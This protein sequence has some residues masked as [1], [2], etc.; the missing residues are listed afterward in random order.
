MSEEKRK[1]GYFGTILKTV[2]AVVV[3]GVVVALLSGNEE[4]VESPKLLPVVAPSGGKEE[5]P[6]QEVATA[7][8]T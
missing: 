5:L 3:I 6:T 2:G 7:H 8:W 4:E 1:S